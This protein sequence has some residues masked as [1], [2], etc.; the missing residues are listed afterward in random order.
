MKRSLALLFSLTLLLS[1]LS[2]CNMSDPIDEEPEYFDEETNEDEASRLLITDFS[3]PVYSGATLDPILCSDGV[4]QTLSALLYEGLFALSPAFEAEPRLCESY[5]YDAEHY[6]YHFTLRGDVSFCDGSALTAKD[7]ISGFRRAEESKRYQARFRTVAAYYAKGTDT[8]VVSLNCDNA[9]FPALLDIPIVKAGTEQQTVPPGTGPYLYIA[10]SEGDYLLSN[11][12]WWGGEVSLPQ[13]PLVAVKDEDAA[14]YRFSGSE[15][16]LLAAELSGESPVSTAGQVCITDAPGAT[17]QYLGFRDGGLFSSTALRKALSL[18]IRRQELTRGY[19]SGHALAAE[20]PVSPASPLYPT[21]LATGYNAAAFAAAMSEL[22]YELTDEQKHTARLI[23]PEGNDYKLSIA[24]SVA[25]LLAPYG[26][27]ITVRALPW[28]DYLEA[29]HKGAYDIYY[30][31]VR[32]TP[33][34]DLRP[35]I[36]TYGTLNYGHYANEETDAL[37][38]GYLSHPCVTTM[39]QLSRKLQEDMPIVP[40]FFQSVSVLTQTQVLSSLTP[41]AV[42]PFYDMAQWELHLD[43]K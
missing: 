1:L 8:V 30:A 23:I 5:T 21:A 38:L 28:A 29:L 13:I 9:A 14:S 10:G 15:I 4:Q 7:V 17:M 20:F 6:T 41:T 43:A 25:E 3:L 26:I 35:L 39:E 33:D 42:N 32:L 12:S 18:G 19:L 34:W 16:Q 31:T 37:L 24:K 11:D 2:G 36:G 22:G 40:L 27:I